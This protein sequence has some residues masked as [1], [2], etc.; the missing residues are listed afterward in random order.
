MPP[1][2]KRPPSPPHPPPP[3]L[4]R[5]GGLADRLGPPPCLRCDWEGG[6]VGSGG[7]GVMAAARRP[8]ENWARPPAGGGARVGFV[9][10]QA[11]PAAR[12]AAVGWA[13]PIAMMAKAAEDAAGSRC[14]H[15]PTSRRV[16]S[17]K[18]VQYPTRG[19]T[20]STRKSSRR[21]WCRGNTWQKIAVTDGGATSGALKKK[22]ESQP[23]LAE[24]HEGARVRRA[25]AG[26]PGALVPWLW[27]GRRWANTLRCGWEAAPPDATG[28]Y[29][30]HCG[31]RH[32]HPTW[33][34]ALP[35]ERR[36]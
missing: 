30:R 21:S 33:R 16:P 34:W 28:C 5:E 32:P 20:Y 35:R 18:I 15:W 17:P 14:R 19:N 13:R 26:T 25:A 12:G 22:V 9:A 8:H 23:L 4:C 24:E 29:S 7:K 10:G 11:A 36:Q 31:G 1:A 2:C 27:L 6:W 3:H